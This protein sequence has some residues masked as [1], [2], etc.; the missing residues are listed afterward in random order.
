MQYCYMYSFQE[1]AAALSYYWMSLYQET[2]SICE[3]ELFYSIV[4]LHIASILSSSSFALS[5]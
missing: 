5:S 3:L 2:L 4:F 1:P